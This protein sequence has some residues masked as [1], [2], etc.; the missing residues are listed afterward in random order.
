V[1]FIATEVNTNVLSVGENGNLFLTLGVPVSFYVTGI[2][3][4]SIQNSY[5]GRAERQQLEV[6][7][8]LKMGE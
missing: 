3:H 8:S 1:S 6:Q 2:Q 4:I 7:G 5:L